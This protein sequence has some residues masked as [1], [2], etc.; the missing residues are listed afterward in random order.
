MY[1]MAAGAWCAQCRAARHT[2]PRT[3]TTHTHTRAR[4]SDTRSDNILALELDVPAAPSSDWAL[5]QGGGP[6]PRAQAAID[7]AFWEDGH[8]LLLGPPGSPQQQLHLVAGDMSGYGMASPAATGAAQRQQQQAAPPP[9]QHPPSSASRRQ[10]G[11]A[12]AAR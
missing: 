7:A 1:P 3:C 8:V 9:K 4:A 11:A 12:S 6:N 2:L 10:P 5:G